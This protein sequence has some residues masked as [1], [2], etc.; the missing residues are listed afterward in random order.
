MKDWPDDAFAG[1]LAAM[2]DGEGHIEINGMCSV[3]VR[4]ANTFRPTLD[5][6]VDRLGFGRVAEYARP[7]D[8]KFKRLFSVDVSNAKDVSRLFAICGRFIHIKAERMDDALA[9]INRVLGEIERIDERNRQIL[10]RIKAGEKQVNIAR[11]LGVSPQLV[12]MV[13][14]G[15]GWSSVISGH[16]A[17]SLAKRF[18]ARS[19]QV[20]RLHGEPE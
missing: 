13:K 20:F 10:D 12:S 3:R 14:K 15:H 6:I 19:S 7:K 5:A 2:I 4:I 1:Y 16:R 11:D 8:S 18:P 9:V 17:R